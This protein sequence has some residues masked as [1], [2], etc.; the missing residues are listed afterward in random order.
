[1]FS[2]NI[3]HFI[4]FTDAPKIKKFSFD[5]NVKEGDATSVMCFATSEIKPLRFQWRKNGNLLENKKHIRAEDSSA[6]SVLVFD[7]VQISD[8]GNY[9]CF[10]STTSGQDSYTA[11]LN[12]KGML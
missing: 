6:Y 1:M 12:V 5:D 8:T 7:S 10:V 3:Q 4:Q 11:E 9:S 2:E